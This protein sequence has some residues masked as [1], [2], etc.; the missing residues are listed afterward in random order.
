MN[1][2]PII[3]GSHFKKLNYFSQSLETNKIPA[4]T[5]RSLLHSRLKETPT[6][7]RHCFADFGDSAPARDCRGNRK[8]AANGCSIVSDSGD[9]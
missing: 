2:F 6:D 7:Q 9:R 3:S 5:L 1:N 8:I 4:I